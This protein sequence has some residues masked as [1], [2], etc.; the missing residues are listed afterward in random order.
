M[1][2]TVELKRYGLYV[3]GEERA[4]NSGAVIRS[5]SPARGEAWAELADA[6]ADDVADAVAAAKAAFWSD[7][8][9]SMPATRR[10]RL[11][12][13]LADLVLENAET[14][15]LA[16]TTENGK[17]YKEMVTQARIVPDWLYYFGGLADKIEGTVIPVPRKSV[18]NYTLREPVGVV[19]IIT[20]WNSPVLLTTFA[21]APALAAG[22]AVVIKPSEV[23]SAGVLEFAKLTEAAGFPPGIVNVVT[24]GAVA[25]AALVD[26][27]DVAKITF[28]GGTGAGKKIAAAAGSRLAGVTMELGGKSPNIVFADADLDAAVVGVL[29]GI[30]AAG[31][32]T[33]VAG[34]RVLVQDEIHDEV[35][36]RL[37]DRAGRIRLGDPMDET[38]EMGP[39]ATEQHLRNI[40][41]YVD[42]AAGEGAQVVSG[43]HRA[44][45]DDFPT[46]FFFEPTIL[47]GITNAARVARE[48]IF[49]PVAAVLRFGDEDEAVSIANDTEFGLAA[50]VWTRDIKRAHRMARRLQA[51]TVWINTYRALTFSSPFGGYKQSGFGRV[52]GIE[53]VNEYLQTKSV[54]CELSDEIQDPFTLKS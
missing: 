46:G 25:G 8:W 36:A 54:W 24:G 19:G 16:E 2:A 39:I 45:L 43:G 23:A 20:P 30:F 6:G 10:G 9:Q 38:T 52:N 31:G 51:G 50:G 14:I 21:L 44:T 53:A 47:T 33:C 26:H 18:L 5:I 15:A 22:N 49:G 28:V 11:M 13:K 4:A 37:A 3:A 29:A 12:M 40:A 32:Q 48:E 1:S 7:E 42:S 35:V 17:L 34:S 41:S 27:P